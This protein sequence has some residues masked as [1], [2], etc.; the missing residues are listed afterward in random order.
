VTLSSWLSSGGAL[1]ALAVGVLVGVGAG[2]PGLGLLLAFFFSSSLLTPGGGRRRAVQVAANGGVAALAALLA[3]TRQPPWHAAFAGALAAA[4]ADTW[5]TE[6]GGRSRSW[7]RLV[8]TG[9]R[10]APGTSGGV[11]WLGSAAG[12]AGAGFVGAVAAGLGVVAARA[13][14]AVAIAGLLGGWADSLLGATLQ[15]QYRCPSC[16]ATGETPRPP[17]GHHAEL[18]AGRAWITN[19]TV[20]LAATLVG[21]A[22]AALAVI[23]GATGLSSR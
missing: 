5:A 21:A 6:V 19:D 14:V 1:A 18:V 20:N 15:A 13:A 2:W 4:A 11:T 17:C 16:G 10:V 7:P 3:L 9:R 8:T 12:A 22:L 23:F